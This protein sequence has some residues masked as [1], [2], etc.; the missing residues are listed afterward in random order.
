MARWK[1]YRRAALFH[2]PCRRGISGNEWS[3]SFSPSRWIHPSPEQDS[4]HSSPPLER[5]NRDGSKEKSRHQPPRSR[6]RQQ[7]SIADYSYP[8]ALLFPNSWMGFQILRTISFA[9]GFS[10]A[11]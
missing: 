4:E 5:S 1:G 10:H 2:L 6:I 3:N 11:L 8:L 9:E 7:P